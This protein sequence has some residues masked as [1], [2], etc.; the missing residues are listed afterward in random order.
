MPL[1]SIVRFDS[2]IVQIL[3]FRHSGASAERTITIPVGDFETFLSDDRSDD[4]QI[5]VN[6]P[7]AQYD[8][9]TIPPVEPKLVSRIAQIEFQRLY[10]G[11]PPFTA[12]FRTI[13]EIAQEGK[14]LKRVAC[15]MA[16]NDYLDSV[17]EPFIRHNKSVTLI[18][19]LPAVLA[20]LVGATPETRSQTLL[21]GYD[22]SDKKCIF[23]LE[24]G[25]VT[26]V[27]YVPSA[28][29]GWSEHDLQNITMT[30]DY[31][32]QT[33]RVR[34]SRTITLNGGPVQPP[35]TPFTPAE[36]VPLSHELQQEYLPHLTVMA[37]MGKIKED[38]RPESYL[39]AF[40]HQKLL[41]AGVW[42]FSVGSFAAVLLA[43]FSLFSILSLQSELD[44]A[45]KLE[46][47]IPE[48]LSSHHAVQQE[49]SEVEPVVT[50]MNA[51]QSSRTL[52]ELL[53][54]L[55]E[56]AGGT[57]RVSSLNATKSG[58][59]ISL[60]LSGTIREKSFAGLQSRF[61]EMVSRLSQIR[62]LA[63]SSQQIDQKSQ[64]FTIE[65]KSEP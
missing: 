13:D 55:P 57:V 38:L 44:T 64:L 7:D 65:M 22:S 17:L 50:A 3:S 54:G 39:T 10:P 6:A 41:R 16:P 48:L 19:T 35:L 63:V 5:I 25:C 53:A 60:T 4:Y 20:H 46:S 33:L 43:L 49:R 14:T 29:A 24:K 8:V 21:C 56:F 51:L 2:E 58:D 26:M 45:R 12:F 9:I 59:A 28:G 18:S 30:L 37:Y 47:T 61:E 27:R 52:P 40:M 34:P 1:H 31:C 62:G 32:F 42:V 23:L 15:C 36:A 11:Y